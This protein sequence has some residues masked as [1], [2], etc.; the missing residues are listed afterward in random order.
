[1]VVWYNRI[2]LEDP[3]DKLA[4]LGLIIL[5][6]VSI[7]SSAPKTPQKPFVGLTECLYLTPRVSFYPKTATYGS[8]IDCLVFEESSGNPNAVGDEGRAKG[9]LQFHSP[10]FQQYCV[11]RF[12]YRNDIW[13]EEIQRNCCA[14]MLENDLG[15]HWSTYK[16]CRKKFAKN[17]DDIK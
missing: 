5:L 10:T 7:L 15:Y 4:V 17:V 8:L 6:V 13:D 14:E 9:I 3:P 11:N 12:N 1:M 2:M 16:Q